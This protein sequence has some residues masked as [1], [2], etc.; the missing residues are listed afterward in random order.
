MRATRVYALVAGLVLLAAGL[1]GLLPPLVSP[2][3]FRFD[4]VRISLLYG[5]V[6]GVLPANVVR[7]ALHVAL[8]LWGLIA[9]WRSFPVARTYARWAAGIFGVLAVMGL[10]PAT[11]TAFGLMPLYGANVWLHGAIALL[12]AAFGFLSSRRPADA[13]IDY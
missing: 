8:G 7:S 12:G 5:D 2:P 10:F 6:A 1:A 4:N 13:Y 3:L 11:S 9:S